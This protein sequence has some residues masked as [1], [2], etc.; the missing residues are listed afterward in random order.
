MRIEPCRNL[1]FVD[2]F[3]LALGCA[4]RAAGGTAAR[5]GESRVRPHRSFIA[6]WEIS[7]ELNWERRRRAFRA[8]QRLILE[9]QR[10]PWT[11]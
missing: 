1:R 4:R 2:V 11:P 6:A 9:K 10:H 3:W 8:L 7:L 5:H